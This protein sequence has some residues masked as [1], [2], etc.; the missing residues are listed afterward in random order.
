MTATARIFSRLGCLLAAF[1]FLPSCSSVC[2]GPGGEVSKVKIYRLDPKQ[3]FQPQVDRAIR[4]EQERLLYGAVSSAER[5]A[6]AGQYYSVFWKAD[7]RSQPV[8]VRFEYRKQ[9]TGLKV[10]TKEEVTEAV[11][12]NNVTHFEVNREEYHDDGGVTS[13]RVT[14]LQGTQELAHADSYLWQ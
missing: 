3:R 7:D 4:F 2:K 9:N 5:N 8:K 6:R 11:K 14:L 10:F 12:K 13:W 1:A